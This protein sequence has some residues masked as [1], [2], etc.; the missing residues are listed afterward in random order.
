MALVGDEFYV[1]NTDA[2]M[3]FP[4][5]EGDT[6]ITRR[7]EGRD[8]PGGPI[9]HHWTKDL[10]ASPDGR[11]LYATVGSNSNAGENGIEAEKSRRGL[12]VDPATGE[13]AS[14]R[15]ACAIRTGRDFTRKAAR[16]G[17]RSTSATKSA[18]ISCRTT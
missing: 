7:A 16:C 5:H 11:K 14:S 4:Y 10:T 17:S 12:E 9:N 2:V 13:C 6:K 15:P 1:A 8:L 18:A 3:M